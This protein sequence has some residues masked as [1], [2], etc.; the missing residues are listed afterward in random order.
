MAEKKDH[1]DH[2]DKDKKNKNPFQD[3]LNLPRTDF[4]LRAHAQEKEPAIIQQWKDQALFEKAT[5]LNEGNEAFILHDGPPYANGHIHMGTA[6][7]KILKDIVCKSKRMSG[8]Y[9]PVTPGW[10]C[11]GL[12]IELK[13]IAELGLD[14]TQITDRKTLK[15]V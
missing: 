12:P 7:N 14:G 11:H 13:A 9:V 6:F 8:K 3:T 10:D 5:Q 15:S 1:K 2:L 4:S